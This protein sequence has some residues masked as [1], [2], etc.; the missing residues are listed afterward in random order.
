MFNPTIQSV[1]KRNGTLRVVV[2]Y[3]DS[4]NNVQDELFINSVQDLKLT[5]VTRAQQLT[6]LYAFADT[7][8]PGVIDISGSIKTK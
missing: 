7:F 4:S 6:D 5:L 2:N 3:T 1:E 8:S